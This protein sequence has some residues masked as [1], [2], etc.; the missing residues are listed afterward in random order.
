MNPLGHNDVYIDYG[1]CAGQI[2]AHKKYPELKYK[3]AQYRGQDHCLVYELDSSFN[4]TSDFVRTIMID[5]LLKNYEK[6]EI[7]GK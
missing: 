4:A 7:A 6:Y 3:V 5:V 2:W 1:V